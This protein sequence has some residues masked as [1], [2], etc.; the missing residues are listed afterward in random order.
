MVR[1]G[2]MKLK[3][4]IVSEKSICQISWGSFLTRRK[5]DEYVQE[6]LNGCDCVGYCGCE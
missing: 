1:R 4:C 5:D 6:E 3:T 2:Y